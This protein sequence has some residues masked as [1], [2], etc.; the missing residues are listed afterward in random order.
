MLTSCYVSLGDLK[1]KENWPARSEQNKAPRLARLS[2]LQY[3]SATV[4]TKD[5]D[6]KHLRDRIM[7]ATEVATASVATYSAFAGTNET[8]TKTTAAIAA[9]TGVIQFVRTF[10]SDDYAKLLKDESVIERYLDAGPVG[11][12]DDATPDAVRA[13]A[14]SLEDTMR[15]FYGGRFSTDALGNCQNY[16]TGASP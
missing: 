10:F 1:R 16:L 6:T 3:L 15:G 14:D 7:I 11:A 5:A 8:L 12:G 13:A 9:S 2:C 4:T